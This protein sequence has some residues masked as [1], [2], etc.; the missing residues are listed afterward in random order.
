M[1]FIT[2]GKTNWKLLLIVIILAIIVG[3]GALWYE[4]GLK[5][6]YQP[7]EIQKTETADWETFTDNQ[8]GF[9]IKYPVIG[10]EIQY[11][12]E[13]Q[14]SV[15][16]LYKKGSEAYSGISGIIELL[17]SSCY[18]YSWKNIIENADKCFLTEFKDASFKQEIIINSNVKAYEIEV[19]F[20]PIQLSRKM[21]GVIVPLKIEYKDANYRPI[22]FLGY[23]LDSSYT[24]EKIRVFRQMLSTFKFIESP[25]S[26]CIDSDVSVPNNEYIKGFVEF[27]GVK[28][29]DECYGVLNHLQEYYCAADGTN[30]KVSDIECL[31][32]CLNGACIK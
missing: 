15:F 19:K 9:K 14:L 13:D 2:Q 8:H 3:V 7:V 11:G 29:W 23:N 24:T 18:N 20:G 12:S 17:D 32:G 26:S 25:V 22:L 5:K 27:N 28:H 30:W 1:P 31:K 16:D 6:S 21:F 4:K 10:W